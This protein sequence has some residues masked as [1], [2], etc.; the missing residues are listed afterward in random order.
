MSKGPRRGGHFDY[1]FLEKI[2]RHIIMIRIAFVS[3][4]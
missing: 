2:H 4:L 3:T 1:I